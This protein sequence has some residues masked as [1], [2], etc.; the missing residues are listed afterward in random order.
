MY[1]EIAV[2]AEIHAHDLATQR[3]CEQATGCE[4]INCRLIVPDKPAYDVMHSNA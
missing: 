2:A 3:A 4:G 1:G